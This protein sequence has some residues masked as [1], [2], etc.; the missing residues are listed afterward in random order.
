MARRAN[1]PHD[2]LFGL[3][4][5]QNGMVDQSQLVAAFG[6]WTLAKDRPMAEVLVSQG[7]LSERRRALLE[8]L[9]GEHLAMHGG[10]PE[11]SLAAIPAGRSTRE[12]LAGLGDPE[13]EA[14]LAHFASD[15]DSDIDPDRTGTYVVGTATSGGQRFRILR[16]HARGGLGAVFVA[17]DAELHREV[18]LKQILDRHAD[19]T[20]SRQ[21]F[22]LEAEITGG[23]EH[24]GIVPVYGLGSY[25]DGRPYYA[26]RF[27]KGDSL[28]DAIARFHA[29]EA[30][31][32]SPGAR[33]LALRELL[34]RFVDVC[35]AIEYAH[36]RGV[37]HRD[38]KPGNVIVGRHG[39]TLV[40]DWGLAKASGKADLDPSAGERPLT[41]SSA[42]G[43]AETLPG[44][45]LGTPAY[46]SPEQ[47]RGDLAALG[48]QSDVYSLGATLYCL[49][50]GKAPFEGDDMGVL[51]RVQAGDFPP[52]RRHDPTLDG[53]L[54][55]VCLKAMAARPAHRYP[56]CR[57]L[58]DD[59]ERW[60][61]DEPVSAWHEP[62]LRRARR[63]ARRHKPL[64]ACAAALLAATVV[65]LIAGTILLSRAN[66]RTE[67]QREIAEVNYHKARA[68]VDNYFTRVSQSKLLEVPGLQPLR[69]ELL[70]SALK[71]YK[72]FLRERADD[73][74]SQSGSAAAYA[75][76]A[77]LTQ[78]I[79]SHEEALGLYRQAL[80]LYEQ[81]V[82]DHPEEPFYH[83]VDLAI[84][85]DRYGN[86]LRISGH[87]DE[88]MRVQARGLALRAAMARA[89][90][91][92]ARF[93]DE[94]AQSHLGI[95]T[96][97]R[98]S[99]RLDEAM[100]HFA[101]ALAIDEALLQRTDLTLDLPGDL[102]SH[103]ASPDRLRN[104]LVR[105]LLSISHMQYGLGRHEESLRS[106]RRACDIAEEMARAHP[107][108]ADFRYLLADCYANLAVA[109]SNLHGPAEGLRT[110]EQARAMLE[111][112]VAENPTVTAYQKLLAETSMN[113]GQRLE[114]TGQTADAL[115]QYDKAGA[116]LSTAV[117]ANPT[118]T[119]L[120]FLVARNLRNLANALL[121]A[122]KSAEGLRQLEEART[123]L[124]RLASEDPAVLDFRSDLAAT[125]DQLGLWYARTQRRDEARRELEAARELREELVAEHP[126]VTALQS[127]LATTYNNLARLRRDLGQPDQA[128]ALYQKALGILN[129]LTTEHPAAP[130]YRDSLAYTYRGLGRIQ[131]RAGRAD[132]A[133]RSLALARAI[134][135]QR[136]NVIL[137]A[138]YNLA[139]DLALSV[140]LIG[141]GQASPSSEVQAE[142]TKMADAAIEALRLALAAGYPVAI[143]R[144]DPDMEALRARPDF[145]FL[146]MD[147]DFPADPFV[148]E[149]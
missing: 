29:D 78:L 100:N 13:I 142:R 41:P 36:S 103:Y 97:L 86:L 54:E 19:D 145:Q 87:A 5:L 83:R 26:M 107:S 61:A 146:V 12:R 82:R 46:M 53:A 37:L 15:S 70:E 138:R 62:V 135:E 4:A 124:Q 31:K 133:I 79:G 121:K 130:D 147:P 40:V 149:N 94:L 125:R 118:Y 51:C 89:H 69:K 105:S 71:Y 6:A 129:R 132:E 77:A 11:K 140:P 45:A 108:D 23:L 43:S 28:K 66:A 22:L 1:A 58:A 64:V 128:M 131:A 102:G 55:A 144:D 95:G 119:W 25:G 7:V 114:Q 104:H 122:G 39:E 85:C 90:P 21:R 117:A 18:A 74:A 76:A 59:V 72:D 14:S 57:A 111:R 27:I 106:R 2:L 49:L 3:L 134:D 148:R 65:G 60:M 120:R 141:A 75:R 92:S 52:P 112:L 84:V 56:T 93:Q 8:A 126:R 50:T 109:Q 123:V 44:S 47:A 91:D 63:W 34:R 16:P 68:A 48:R 32:A 20:T 73:A 42:S 96:L 99:G 110:F 9:V 30:S 137:L 127:G 38:I 143:P 98:E 10:D 139:C 17:L 136:A 35:N 116:I 115:A 81:L 113:I 88:A 101:T 24:P 80:A 33:S 67:N